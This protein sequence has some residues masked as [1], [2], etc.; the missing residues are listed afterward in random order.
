[1]L[2]PSM[3]SG[4]KFV[5]ACAMILKMLSLAGSRSNVS[6]TAGGAVSIST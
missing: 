4:R 5:S 1:M 6:F 3:M 2:V